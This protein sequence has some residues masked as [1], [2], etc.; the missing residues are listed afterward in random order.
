MTMDVN[1]I[2]WRTGD[3]VYHRYVPT[4]VSLNGSTFNGACLT[5]ATKL[6]K[7]LAYHVEPYYTHIGIVIVIDSVPY[8]FHLTTIQQY[9]NHTSSCVTGTPAI[10]SLS[11]M[12]K[13]PG[14]L[15][16]N[17][18]IGPTINVD[19]QWLD[20]FYN[21]KFDH[22]VVRMLTTNKFGITKHPKNTMVCT[23]FVNTV[24]HNLGLTN[25]TKP[26]SLNS[27]RY[28]INESQHYTSKPVI[29][30]TGCYLLCNRL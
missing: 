18:Y 11:V 1:D 7:G 15:Y 29:V 20:Q 23:D 16:R 2:Q 19:N 9:D 30:K 5:I 27:I 28:Y 12:I 10:I 22:N 4:P 13:Y 17:R 8:L 21:I 26:S 24:L 6:I 3:I 14:N 25:N